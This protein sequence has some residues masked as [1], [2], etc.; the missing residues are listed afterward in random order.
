[1]PN[2]E[3]LAAIGERVRQRRRELDLTQ[4]TL[5]EKCGLVKSFISEVE[6]G[7][8]SASGLNYLKL[9]QA[10]DVDVQWLLTGSVRTHVDARRS[11][12]I[13]PLLSQIAEE[14]AW[15]YRQTLDVA[16]VL[17]GMVARRTRGG[18]LW[19]P[20]REYILRIARAISS[21]DSE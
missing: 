12:Q 15:S 3:Q 18:D 8:S 7:R 13:P 11:V 14:Q 4:E 6:T 1:M 16:S 21:E 9:A 19:R 10:L 20:S 2:D 5:A 17:D